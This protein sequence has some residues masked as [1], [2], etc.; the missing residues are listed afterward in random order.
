MKTVV[1]P[2][3]YDSKPESVSSHFMSC[4]ARDQ[5]GFVGDKCLQKVKGLLCVCVRVLSEEVVSKASGLKEHRGRTDPQ[6][7]HG[8]FSLCL[9]TEEDN[10]TMPGEVAHPRPSGEWWVFG[11]LTSG[12]ECENAQVLLQGIIS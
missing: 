1:R 10:W 8:Y 7:S 6:K 12:Y 11:Q 2:H 4:I 3:A 5:T 9:N